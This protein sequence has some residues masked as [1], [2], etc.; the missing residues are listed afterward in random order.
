MLQDR[1]ATPQD[2]SASFQQATEQAIRALEAYRAWLQAQLGAMPEKVSVGR[3]NYEFFLHQVALLPYS[4][5]QLLALGRQEL[6]RS[7][8]FEQYEKQRNRDCP[9]CNSLPVFH[10]R[11]NGPKK[12]NWRSANF[13]RRRAS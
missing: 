6:D 7:V 9:N 12:K 13:S 10:W 4:P 1:S 11:S 3:E 5:Q 2:L 8:A